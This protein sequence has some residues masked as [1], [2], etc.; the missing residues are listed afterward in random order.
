MRG[1]LLGTLFAYLGSVPLCVYADGL[2]GGAEEP[3][4][5]RR[6]YRVQGV[7]HMLS[8]EFI[9]LALCCAAFFAIISVYM[10]KLSEFCRRAVAEVLNRNAR[11]VTMARMAEV[12]VA[13]TDLTD[14]YDALLASHKKL[15]SRIGMRKVREKR[16][17]GAESDMPDPRIDPSGYKRAIRLKLRESGAL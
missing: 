13:L 9:V 12:E 4:R 3:P 1:A 7:T 6:P 10:Y 15:R 11:S 8:T 14:A 17:N 2:A 16:E 5:K